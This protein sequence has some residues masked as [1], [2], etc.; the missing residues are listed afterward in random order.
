[1]K[2]KKRSWN[3]EVVSP[4]TFAFSRSPGIVGACRTS[5]SGRKLTYRLLCR[6]I[7]GCAMRCRVIWL[8]LPLMPWL[9]G[10]SGCP[11]VYSEEPLGEEPAA[12][13]GR[14]LNGSWIWGLRSSQ[15][16]ILLRLHVL[17]EEKGFLIT[18]VGQD[19]APKA[20]DK[21]LHCDPPTKV[22][23]KHCTDPNE[24]PINCVSKWRRVR[25]QNPSFYFLESEPKPDHPYG[26]SFVL[27]TDAHWYVMYYRAVEQE[28]LDARLS[29]LIEKGVLPGHIDSDKHAVLEHLSPDHYRV[30]L[31]PSTGLFRWREGN[32]LIKLPS[33]LDPCSKRR[34]VH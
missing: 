28:A 26:T 5:A 4:R 13:S 30:L 32:P 19:F 24:Y 11:Q 8:L 20:K 2:R 29:V 1:M 18:W 17:D 21:S 27:S 14:D 12:L 3:T 31:S 16:P 33:E 34:P 25:S 22:V 7:A 6:A 10:M 9:L 15:Q 23:V